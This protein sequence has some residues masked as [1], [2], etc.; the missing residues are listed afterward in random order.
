ME[1]TFNQPLKHVK[2]NTAV[3]AAAVAAASPVLVSEA[4]FV[5]IIT[6][7]LELAVAAVAAVAKAAKAALVVA[8]HSVFMRTPVPEPRIKT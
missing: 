3:A 4:V 6:V 1:L 2:D 5:T 8:H 7:T